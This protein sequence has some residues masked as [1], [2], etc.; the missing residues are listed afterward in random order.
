MKKLLIIPLLLIL[1]I[2]FTSAYELK[3]TDGYG[4]DFL[5]D[6]YN[7]ELNERSETYESCSID[8]DGIT[9]LYNVKVKINNDQSIELTTNAVHNDALVNG[10][11][12]ESIAE[13]KKI[14]F[15]EYGATLE[16]NEGEE[17]YLSIDEKVVAYVEEKTGPGEFSFK[18]SKETI[19]DNSQT[20]LHLT[21]TDE[22]L[23]IINIAQ[24]YLIFNNYNIE[25]HYAKDT[26]F[27]FEEDY[28]YISINENNRALQ[29][30]KNNFNDEEYHNILESFD[31]HI[32]NNEYSSRIILK[33]KNL[34]NFYNEVQIKSLTNNNNMYVFPGNANGRI[35]EDFI[36]TLNKDDLVT[37]NLLEDE[38]KG[39]Y[40]TAKIE[41]NEDEKDKG[42]IK[43][44]LFPKEIQFNENDESTLGKD[45]TIEL[46]HYVNE[47]ESS[48]CEATSCYFSKNEETEGSYYNLRCKKDY[49]KFEI[50]TD[51][52]DDLSYSENTWECQTA[53]CF[54]LLYEYGMP[55]VTMW[56]FNRQDSKSLFNL[57]LAEDLTVNTIINFD[58]L[59]EEVED[60]LLSKQFTE[61]NIFTLKAA[62]FRVE[63]FYF[64]PD[65]NTAN[66][67]DAIDQGKYISMSGGQ[68][69]SKNKNKRYSLKNGNNN[70]YLIAINQNYIMCNPDCYDKNT[71]EVA[72][73]AE[74]TTYG[75]KELKGRKTGSYTVEDAFSKLEPSETCDPSLETEEET[76]SVESE[77]GEIVEEG[78]TEDLEKIVAEK[79]K[80]CNEKN[81][82][83]SC[84]CTWD[85]TNSGTAKTISST[86]C[87]NNAE[88]ET[89]LCTDPGAYDYM[90]CSDTLKTELNQ[91]DTSTRSSDDGT[92]TIDDEEEISPSNCNEKDVNKYR[93]SD[94]EHVS[95]CT[96]TEDYYSWKFIA[97]CNSKCIQNKIGTRDEI[98]TEFDSSNLRTTTKC[99][100]ANS[101]DYACK[102]DTTNKG[103]GAIWTCNYVSGD[104]Y[105]SPSGACN[106][107]CKEDLISGSKS[108][109]CIEEDTEKIE[110]EI[111]ECYQFDFEYFEGAVR[112][113]YDECWSYSYN[114][115][116]NLWTEPIC[117]YDIEDEVYKEYS[118][119]HQDIINSLSLISDKERGITRLETYK[120]DISGF[121][122]YCN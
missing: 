94:E 97:Y 35:S 99:S 29:I 102:I 40:A 100:E 9:K 53:D 5:E 39:E 85:S 10:L 72:E 119:N 38:E 6:K 27:Q 47:E 63:D 116:S 77:T 115:Q 22:D 14:T 2:S 37:I 81:E 122:G 54:N 21:T 110:E 90:C 32:E 62:T 1:L 108:D 46:L 68:V 3:C 118:I 61:T 106:K 52:M 107:I 30:H 31:E 43:A 51:N 34:E 79:D 24:D 73:Y 18:T 45:T 60:S 121:E 70:Q 84:Q 71:Y 41:I 56:N 50:Q 7:L 33:N 78:T 87:K 67:I 66:I 76:E 91:K 26:K 88:C 101:N 105:W 103:T 44:C 49:P 25:V 120:N 111:H 17:T 20:I 93:C 75:C 16:V 98:C 95:Q 36:L 28:L 83:W 58:E 69:Y 89:N 65:R 104:W 86:E 74:M 114:F 59:I 64:L 23:E 8:I 57:R 96:K 4:F 55:F 48:I 82:G 11:Y 80:A 13:G 19:D 112:Y 15:N 109:V 92:T 117:T 113:N 42:Q 12:V